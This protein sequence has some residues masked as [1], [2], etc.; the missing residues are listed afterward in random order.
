ME[1]DMDYLNVIGAVYIALSGGLSDEGQRLV[2]DTLL[3]IAERA[4]PD[5]A[6]FLRALAGEKVERPRLT[7]VGGAA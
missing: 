4:P 5:E 1:N 2:D 7:L 6:T 3:R